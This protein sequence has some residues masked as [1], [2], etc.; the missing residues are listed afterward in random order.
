M[1]RITEN[2]YVGGWK[3]ADNLSWLKANKVTHIA[4]IAEELDCAFPQDFKYLHIK[5][6]DLVGF[7]LLPYFEEITDFVHKAITEAH[8][9]VF[10]HCMWGISRSC[11]SA[12][13]YFMRFHD[14]TFYQAKNL[15]ESKR[16]ECCPNSGFLKQLE[17]YERRLTETKQKAASE[18][19]KGESKK[20][21][22]FSEQPQNPSSTEKSP[23]KA[24]ANKSRSKQNNSR[25]ISP[26]RKEES[27]GISPTKQAEAQKPAQTEPVGKSKHEY[28]CRSCRAKLFAEV[29]VIK[30]RPKVNTSEIC[31][32]IFIEQQDWMTELGENQNKLKCPVPECKAKLGDAIWS[33]SK[34]SCGYWVA[35]AFQIHK[36]KV[37]E[38][39]GGMPIASMRTYSKRP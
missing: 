35:P 34:C 26:A 36:A 5:A 23:A 13:A 22:T 4:C 31:T 14:M 1:S 38:D 12:I 18:E 6:D 8:G 17:E 24:S 20:R 16:A 9:V 15:V 30:H 32:S 19:S 28:K 2:I 29:D 10:I 7:Q 37:D 39:K 21:V 27:K 3:Q 25:S 11:T 33:G